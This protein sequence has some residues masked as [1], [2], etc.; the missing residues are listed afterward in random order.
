MR[1]ILVVAKR[2]YRSSVRTKSFLIAVV[3]MPVFMFGG[4]GLQVYLED[5]GDT[6]VKTVAVVDYSGRLSDVL[7]KTA[8]E[9]NEREATDKATGRQMKSKIAVETVPAPNDG[10]DR[11][12]TRAFRSRAQQKPLRFHRNHPRHHGCENWKR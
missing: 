11:H 1:K 9:Y 5:R 6:D 4:I 2:E 3:L 10:T 12:A 7:V 8:A